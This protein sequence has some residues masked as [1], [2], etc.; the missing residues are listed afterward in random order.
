M[1]IINYLKL[2]K[3]FRNDSF[4]IFGVIKKKFV[5]G[6]KLHLHIYTLHLFRCILF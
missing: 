1:G 3:W 2:F 5:R 4:I 6:K